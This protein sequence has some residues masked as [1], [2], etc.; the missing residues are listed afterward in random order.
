MALK[1]STTIEGFGPALK[2]LLEA[3]A[4]LSSVPITDGPP[5]PGTFDGLE[6]IAL[7]DVM[8][9]QSVRALNVSNRPRMESYTQN[10]LVSVVQKSRADHATPSARAWALFNAIHNAIR[11]NHSLTGYYTDDGQIV[12]A[13]IGSGSFRKSVSADASVREASIEF[14]IRVDA[15]I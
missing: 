14:G 11:D 2:A 8:F 15:R 4:T 6:W 10:V 9:E 12:A 5:A 7:L 13:Q 3:Q 1:T